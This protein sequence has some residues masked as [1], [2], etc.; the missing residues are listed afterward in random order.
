MFRSTR[1]DI[2]LISRDDPVDESPTEASGEAD[3]GLHVLSRAGLLFT[4]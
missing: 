1:L 4:S 2:T 3:Y